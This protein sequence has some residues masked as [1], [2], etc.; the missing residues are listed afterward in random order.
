MRLHATVGRLLYILANF[1]VTFKNFRFEY[2]IQM[3]SD[4]SRFLL[5]WDS[6]HVHLP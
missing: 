2:I 1:Y 3:V 6:M 5:V 4:R